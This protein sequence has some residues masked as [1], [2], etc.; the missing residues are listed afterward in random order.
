MGKT[1]WNA[2]LYIDKHSFVYDHGEDLITLLDPKPHERV[3]DLGCGTGQLTHQ[4]GQMAK[5]VIGMDHSPA[6]IQEA[7]ARFP[8]IHFVIGKAS[9]FN[10]DQKFDSIFSNATL[11]WVKDHRGAIKCM[12]NN[13]KPMG[14]VVLEFGGKGNVQEIIGQLRISL[15]KRGYKERSNVNLWY[16]PTIGD[17]TSALEE[18]GFRVTFAQHFD[19]P[20]KLAD[21]K[22]GIKDWLSMFGNEFFDQVPAEKVEEIKAEVQANVADKCLVNDMWFVDYKRIRVVAVKEKL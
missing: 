12:F 17:Y 2:Q 4:I 14:K 9:N 18:F 1:S 15:S 3:L 5:E 16:F 20:T 13:V 10:F 7:R 6:M 8:T 11:H 19:R 21:K 22:S